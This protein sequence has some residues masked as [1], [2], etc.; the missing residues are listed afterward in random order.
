MKPIL[1]CLLA[2]GIARGQFSIEVQTGNPLF[3]GWYADPEVAVFQDRYWIFPTTSAA[4]DEQTYFDAFSS[5]NLM[6]WKKHERILDANEVTWA[7]RAMWA[8][9]VVEKEGEYFFFF[10][11][12]DIQSDEELGG[13][14]VARAERPEGPYRDHLG[15]PLIGKFHHGAQPIDQF[16]FEDGGEWW[17]VYG[18]WGHCNVGRLNDDFTGFTPFEDGSTFKE[19]TPEGY[20]EGPVMFRRQGKLYF[21]WS[22]GKWS[23]PNYQVAYAIGDSP[24][25]PFE[26]IGV[27]LKQ[28]PEIGTGA[29]HHSVLKVPGKDEWHVIYHRRQPGVSERDHRVTCIDRMEFDE[30]GRIQP[31]EI[32]AEGVRAE[33]IRVE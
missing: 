10:G 29:G 20:V 5:L 19:I 32:T 31:I 1:L 2:A 17:I 24:L 8:P 13:I 26:R 28:D 4:Y 16:V 33:P 30:E 18:G 3:E 25:G 21:M 11:A 14:G 23:G 22:E 9:S 27:V 7:K 15:K 12:N 6:N